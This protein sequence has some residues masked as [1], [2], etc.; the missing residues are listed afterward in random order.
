MNE[1]ALRAVQER[2]GAQI[3]PLAAV[4]AAEAEIYAPCAL[5]GALN[6][7]TIPQLRAKIVCGAANNQLAEPRH[8]RA[9][10]ERG[11]LYAPDYL[12]NAGGVIN[13]G[14]EAAGH[15]DIERVRRGVEGIADTAREL[16]ALAQRRQAPTSEV[17]DELARARLQQTAAAPLFAASAAPVAAAL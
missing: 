12:V 9:L 14:A 13:V 4:A 6:D 15:Y 5:G 16:F 3:V 1:R 2:T 10:H 11:I 8:G 7:E 17:V